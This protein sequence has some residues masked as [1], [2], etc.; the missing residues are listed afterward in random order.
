MKK[1]IFG[2]MPE[3]LQQELLLGGYPG[4][5]PAAI[6]YKATWP[7]EKILRCTV[8]T[9]HQTANINNIHNIALILV[10]EF[11][12]L[13]NKYYR[14]KLYDPTFTTGFREGREP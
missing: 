7:D 3:E 4:N 6:V 9:L 10:G 14:S 5:T 12:N 8:G 2:L 13:N 1:E 11:L